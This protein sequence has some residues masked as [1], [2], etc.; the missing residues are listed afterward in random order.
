MVGQTDILLDF[1]MTCYWRLLRKCN[2]SASISLRQKQVP[3]HFILRQPSVY[4]NAPVYPSTRFAL[5][6]KS[7]LLPCGWIPENQMHG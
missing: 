3:L 1:R 6:T 4:R 2:L 7:L 5:L